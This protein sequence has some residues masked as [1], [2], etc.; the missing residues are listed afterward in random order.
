MYSPHRGKSRA[1]RNAVMM[2]IVARLGGAGVNA[3]W[4]GLNEMTDRRA[5]RCRRRSVELLMAEEIPVTVLTG[6]LG[7]GK[8]TLFEPDPLRGSWARVRR[9]RQ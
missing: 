3:H 8:T 1:A 9:H 7:A 5:D 6:Y 2:M 4:L